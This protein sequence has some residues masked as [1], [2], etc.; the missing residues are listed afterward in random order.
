MTAPAPLPYGE[1]PSPIDA[2]AVA[3]GS[4]SFQQVAI[5][6]QDVWWV[7][8]RPEEAG[9]YV[10]MRA[11][12]DGAAHDATPPGFSARTLVN[13]Y[14][15][16]SMAAAGGRL[17]FS[18]LGPAG[19]DQRLWRL[20]PGQ[21]PVPI[22]PP[23]NARYA[24]GAIDAA[25]GLIFCVLEDS[26]APLHGQPSQR[27]AALDLTGAA[28]PIIVAEG[29]DF[30]AAPR[31]SPDGARLCFLR[32]NY[33]SMPWD[34]TELCVVDLDADGRPGRARKIAGAPAAH[35]D[36]ALN[37]VLQ[38]AMRFGDEA[39]MTPKWAPDGSLIFVSDR[40]EID[41]E[42][43]LNLHR[44]AGAEVSAITAMAAEFAAPPWS[45]GGSTFGVLPDGGILC[46]FSQGGTWRL[47]RVGPDGAA[48][49]IDTPFT[50]IEHL[51]VGDG[52]A[53]F[54]GASFAD[55]PA[56]IRHD[57][58]SG[59]FTALRASD[60]GMTDAARA[61][62]AAPEAISFGDAEAR[63]H[64]FFH[65]PFNPAATGP[66]GEKPPLLIFIH[67]GPT[68]A[69][70]A[71]L[72]L[73]IRYFTSR[74]FGVV[75]VNYRGS[76]GFGRRFHQRM[77]G[78]WGEADLADCERAAAFLIDR[79]D[80]D[81]ARVA[82][83]GGSS[84]GYTTLALA[85]FSDLLCCAASYYGISDLEMI[86]THT[87]KLEARYAELL[88]GPYPGDKARF[89]ARSPLFHA[90]DIACPLIL[91]QG[92]DDPVVPPGQAQVLIDALMARELPVA[93]EFYEGESHGF[94]IKANIVGS[95]E[96]E[97]SF[98]GAIMGFVPAGDPRKPDIRNLKC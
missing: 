4:R 71:A 50:H 87:D 38:D 54:V 59:A 34:G 60:A 45:L 66:A 62:F 68:A 8:I 36:P 65:A 86:A 74:G 31:L 51:H 42:R 29:A 40:T 69:A 9:R 1:W 17:V 43:W 48:R 56:V 6:G 27:I 11:G 39:I 95:L 33:P 77:Y 46:A 82:S 89:K 20:D 64:G 93:W 24:D 80:A 12:P 10:V 47:A 19:A 18:N 91:F 7:E 35:V 81:P 58:A 52:F 30:Y 78:A 15:G 63:A 23:R 79:G 98:Y 13:S 73:K 84:G 21:A 76:T 96:E 25:R 22:T 2:E 37:P 26:D 44:W 16:G 67:G 72:S 94:R 53:A 41:G 88:I 97:L 14:G 61:C 90:D 75:D 55:P 92:R 85:T 70:S 28:P 57:L 32:W 3:A 49:V 83:R 5:D